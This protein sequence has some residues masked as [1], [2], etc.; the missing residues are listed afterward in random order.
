MNSGFGSDT[1][2]GMMNANGV[3]NHM[4]MPGQ[5]IS[6][7]EVLAAGAMLAQTELRLGDSATQLTHQ[8][9]MYITLGE[10]PAYMVELRNLLANQLS[11][12]FNFV[13]V[14]GKATLNIQMPQKAYEAYLAVLLATD[15]VD[16]TDVNA[17]NEDVAL[18][19][20]ENVIRPL[21]MSDASVSSVQNTLVK[22]GYNIDFTGYEQAF[23]TIRN[24]YKSS[25]LV[26]DELDSTYGTAIN[27]S[28]EKYLADMNLGDL[29]NM[30]AEKNSGINVSFGASLVNLDKDYEALYF[31]IGAAGITE[32]FGLVENVASKLDTM[33]GTAVVLLLSDVDDDL[34]FKTTT[35]LNLNGFTVNGNIVGQGSVRVVD[36]AIDEESC[37]TVTGTISGNVL[38][39]GGKYDSNVAAFIPEGYEQG[40]DGVVANKFMTIVRDK[41]GNIIVRLNAG[42]LS[43][44]KIPDI[45]TLAA[46]I[47]VEILLNGYSANKLYFN[48]Y[49]VYEL[50]VDDLV[51]LYAATDRKEALM[52]KVMAMVNGQD[53]VKILNTV[54]E[55]ITDFDGLKAIV[56]ADLANGT[57]SPLF[58]YKLTTGTWGISIHY[59][60]EDDSISADI[61]AGQDQDRMLNIVLC[62]TDAE[63][64]HV[65]NLLG[66]LADTT[67][68]DVSVQATA[69]KK[70]ATFV[71]TAGL[72]A[73]VKIDFSKDPKYAIMF[74]VIVADGIGAPANADL[75]A[76]LQAY[77]ETGDMSALA[78]AFN[79]VTFAQLVTAVEN[80]QR[81]DTFA[82]M[83]NALGLSGYDT[84]DVAEL[85]AEIDAFAKLLGILA[86]RVDVTGPAITMDRFLNTQ[87]YAY[88]LDKDHIQKSFLLNLVAGYSASLNF[89]LIDVHT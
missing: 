5:V 88:T 34:T 80:F 67:D 81:T 38:L 78:L 45:K 70:D 27:I 73:D 30:I 86:R 4:A 83:L 71:F 6:D 76:G 3:I 47:L 1:I 89:E 42:M 51:G 48:D 46:D 54:L 49:M 53:L 24:F 9:P 11:P 20:L 16:I 28:I 33:K 60:E 31:D 41:A 10:V 44:N 22:F 8:L 7:Q 40:E 37:G 21:M 35:V 69:G 32:K 15:N 77:F 18:G 12:Y 43:T 23:E 39:A 58:S 72:N 59:V 84:A 65:A 52:Q 61:T 82:A 63:K 75:V 13:C 25:T 50:T 62:G 14:D 85:E 55:D 36:S 56:D 87:T 64:Q 26:Y 19:F 57:E 68:A 2:I 79:K 29:G 17:I 74:S 66:I